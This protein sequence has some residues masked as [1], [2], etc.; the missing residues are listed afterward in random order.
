M[1]N[2]FK[3]INILEDM[4]C[5]GSIPFIVFLLGFFL[6]LNEFRLFYGLII[7]LATTTLLISIIRLIY[8]RLRPE[9]KKRGFVKFKNFFE[10]ID[11]ASFPSMHSAAVSVVAYTL[12]LFN[13]VLIYIAIAMAICVFISRNLMKK[14][15]W[16][17]IA[18]GSL[19]GLATAYSVLRF[20]I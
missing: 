15:Y 5:F 13:S 7:A 12:Y 17:D 6:F 3:H 19:I 18:V 8:H 16:T 20:V 11:D 10:K 4:S 14:H 1:P 2:F 9:N